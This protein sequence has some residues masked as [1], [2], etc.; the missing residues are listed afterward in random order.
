MGEDPQGFQ[1]QPHKSEAEQAGAGM[2]RRPSVGGSAE[3]QA[4]Y[5]QRKP[6][7]DDHR[8]PLPRSRIS[9]FDCPGVRQLSAGR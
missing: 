2:G 8:D 4:A 3:Y 1:P 9:S 5:Q 7:Y 6:S